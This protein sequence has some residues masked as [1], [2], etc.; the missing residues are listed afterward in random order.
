MKSVFATLSSLA[1]IAISASVWAG[2]IEEVAEIAKPRQSAF[3][4][5][6]AE[7]FTAAFADNAVLHSSF[8]PFR[9]E[10]KEAIRA[11]ASQLFQMYPKRSFTVRQP[12]ARAYGDDLVVQDGY[13][14][15]HVVDE[16]GE[17]HVYDTRANTVWKKIDGRWQIISQHISRLPGHD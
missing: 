13:S 8:S 17:P 16:R 7:G 2:P 9:I 14:A 3:A 5:G 10:G 6:S 15:I 12:T 1:T 4:Q 11:Y